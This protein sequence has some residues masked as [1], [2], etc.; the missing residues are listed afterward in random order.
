[1]LIKK[2]INKNCYDI[3]SESSDEYDTTVPLVDACT[4]RFILNFIGLPIL[5]QCCCE[6]WAIS[7]SQAC[8]QACVD[9]V[10]FA[11]VGCCLAAERRDDRRHQGFSSF[12]DEIAEAS[13]GMYCSIK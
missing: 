11:C 4:T 13:E 10:C 5:L 7:V 3:P 9:C 2:E 6:T 8:S 1:M 12:E